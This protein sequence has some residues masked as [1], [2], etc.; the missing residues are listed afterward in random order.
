MNATTQRTT[1][2]VY[3]VGF[4]SVLLRFRHG[5]PKRWNLRWV[6]RDIRTHWRRRSYWNGFLAEVDYPPAGLLHTRCGK[7]W[8]RK[9]AVRD[10]GIQLWKDNRA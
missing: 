1:I 4:M 3:P 7:G 9:A 5:S 6:A 10:L 2:S 8:T